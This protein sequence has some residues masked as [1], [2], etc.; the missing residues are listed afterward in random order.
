MLK[1]KYSVPHDVEFVD[2]WNWLEFFCMRREKV[3]YKLA[4][5]PK[6]KEQVT[7]KTFAKCF[8]YL[9]KEYTYT[10]FRE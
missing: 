9:S 6:S 8:V 10:L 2:L 7:E 5:H 4:M 1:D 3:V